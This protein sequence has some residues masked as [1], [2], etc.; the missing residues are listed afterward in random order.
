VP[1]AV[2]ETVLRIARREMRREACFRPWG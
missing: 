1:A 2:T